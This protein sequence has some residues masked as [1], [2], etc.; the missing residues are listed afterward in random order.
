[1]NSVIEVMMGGLEV[2]DNQQS[3]LKTF[4]GSC[5]AIC[6]Y[7]P[8]IK[9]AG[10]AHV[11]LPKNHSNK[12]PVDSNEIGKFADHA[13]EIILQKM[14]SKGCNINK[15]KAKMA[16]GATIFV[17]ESK[18]NLFNVGPK[19]I[20]A[21][22]SLLAEKKIHLVSEDTGSN[23]GRWVKFNVQTGE[24]TIVSSVKKSEKRI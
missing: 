18:D 5:V 4:V 3:E 2:S 17:H 21:I 9:V 10:M 11:M 6:L 16:G 7:D 15:I 13:I 22:K 12:I 23:S 19:N 24:M 20:K 1:M 8:E 14:I